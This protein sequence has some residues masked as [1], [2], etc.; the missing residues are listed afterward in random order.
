MGVGASSS[1]SRDRKQDSYDQAVILDTLRPIAGSEGFS[2]DWKTKQEP[3]L[4]IADAISGGV[5]EHLMGKSSFWFDEI[6]AATGLTI[7][8]L[9]P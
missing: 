3:L 2:Y 4:W 1:K 9:D 6:E 5:R 7:I 8:Y